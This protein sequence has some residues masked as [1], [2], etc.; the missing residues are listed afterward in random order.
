MTTGPHVSLDV[1]AALVG[2]PSISVDPHAEL[3]AEQALQLGEDVRSA[4][5]VAAQLAHER[6]TMAGYSP[7]RDLTGATQ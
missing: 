6:E 7:A 2:Q 5:L 1:S 3:T 4:A